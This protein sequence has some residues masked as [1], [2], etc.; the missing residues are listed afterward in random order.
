MAKSCEAFAVAPRRDDRGADG[1]LRHVAVMPSSFVALNVLPTARL[2]ADG[3]KVINCRGS[4]SR[5]VSWVL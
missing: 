3:Q 5:S 2:G 1:P 4:E